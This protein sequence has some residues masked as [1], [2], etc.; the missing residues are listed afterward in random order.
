MSKSKRNIADTITIKAL[1]LITNNI[2]SQG[3][4]VSLVIKEANESGEEY[5]LDFETNPNFDFV[6]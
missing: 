5:I 3:N 4:D 2:I 1:N 6:F